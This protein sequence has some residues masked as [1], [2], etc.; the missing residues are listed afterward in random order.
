MKAQHTQAP[1]LAINKPSFLDPTILSRNAV[2]LNNLATKFPV[3]AFSGVSLR[4]K[5]ERNDSRNSVSVLCKIFAG[6]R[7]DSVLLIL[8]T[9]D[10]ISARSALLFPCIVSGK[11]S[12]HSIINPDNT[13][14]TKIRQV[15]RKPLDE[16]KCPVPAT[17]AFSLTYLNQTGQPLGANS[18]RKRV[19]IY[20]TQ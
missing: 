11:L 7:F 1:C 10:D 20:S 6:R 15:V 17:W 16:T 4:R 12:T 3:P 8:Q 13:T 14:G 2:A 18:I 9:F 5:K 19:F